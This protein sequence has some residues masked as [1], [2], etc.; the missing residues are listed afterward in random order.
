MEF[1]RGWPELF[2]CLDA[3]QSNT[4]R[5]KQIQDSASHDGRSRPT[6]SLEPGLRMI[7]YSSCKHEQVLDSEWEHL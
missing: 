2:K 3:V 6:R 5:T 7:G 4:D 1:F